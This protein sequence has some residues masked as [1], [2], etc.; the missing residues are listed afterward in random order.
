MDHLWG[1]I[2]EAANASQPHQVL[3]VFQL[4]TQNNLKNYFKKHLQTPPCR[5]FV[6]ILFFT[7]V[8]G[9]LIDVVVVHELRRYG[10][11]YQLASAVVVF[12]FVAQLG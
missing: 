7:Y 10:Q 3:F 1:V 4:K 9:D 5:G 12:L 11:R 6:L 2:Q 8:A